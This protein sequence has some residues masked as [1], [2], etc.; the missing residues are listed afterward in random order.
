MGPEKKNETQKLLISAAKNYVLDFL[1]VPR[2]IWALRKNKKTKHEN[3]T[4]TR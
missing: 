4:E 2:Y 1:C 3:G